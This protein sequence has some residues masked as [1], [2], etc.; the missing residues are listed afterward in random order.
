MV[1]GEFFKGF[2]IGH[3]L[4]TITPTLNDSF[5]S[6]RWTINFLA[7]LYKSDNLMLKTINTQSFA[8]M[9]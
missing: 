9:V 2:T 3:F 7:E 4:Y 5:Y 1:N 8:E 6:R